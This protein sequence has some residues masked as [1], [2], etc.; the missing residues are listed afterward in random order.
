MESATIDLPG[1]DKLTNEVRGVRSLQTG[2]MPLQELIAYYAAKPVEAVH[3]SLLIRINRLYQD[4]RPRP[5][6]GDARRVEA[7]SPPPPRSS[8]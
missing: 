8:A 7:W 6:R 4:D 1:L 5:V 2:R 3:P